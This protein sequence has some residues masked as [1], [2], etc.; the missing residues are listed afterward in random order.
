MD[1]QL[2]PQIVWRQLHLQIVV[3]VIC[4]MMFGI[5][6][7]EA[8][9][10]FSSVIVCHAQHLPITLKELDAIRQH[11]ELVPMLAPLLQQDVMMAMFLQ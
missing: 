2:D 4:G 11:K 3:Y 1:V 10:L 6:T 7:Q 5:T 8:V 9:T